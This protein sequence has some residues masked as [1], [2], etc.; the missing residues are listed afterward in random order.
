MS[1]K[2]AQEVHKTAELLIEATFMDKAGRRFLE[3]P[4]ELPA[5]Q[6]PGKNKDV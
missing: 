1:W 3:M 2:A 4:R 6:P 5:L